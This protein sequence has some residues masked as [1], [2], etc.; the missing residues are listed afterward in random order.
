[1]KYPLTFYT[2]CFL[3]P[4]QAAAVIGPV[5]LIRPKYRDDVGLLKHELEHVKQGFATLGLHIPLYL[6][7]K[8]YRLWAEASAYKEQ[9]RWPNGTGSSMSL[10]TAARRLAAPEYNLGI[11]EAEAKAYLEA[12]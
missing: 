6:L 3:K 9:M 7:S 1:M 11:T 10:D 2:D 5:I 4:W 8:R 12:L